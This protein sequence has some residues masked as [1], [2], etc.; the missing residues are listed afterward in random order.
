[1]FQPHETLF[2]PKVFSQKSLFLFHV[3]SFQNFPY[4]Q[5]N[6]LPPKKRKIF[7]N[8]SINFSLKTLAS[9]RLSISKPG[10]STSRNFVH[11]FW[12]LDNLHFPNK[13]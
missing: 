2:K 6:H 11:S 8:I 10:Y 9:R 7:A 3:I 4:P 1:M 12:A 5:E 13:L